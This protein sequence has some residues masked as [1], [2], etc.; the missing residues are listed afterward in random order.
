VCISDEPNVIEKIVEEFIIN[1]MAKRVMYASIQGSSTRGVQASSST[2]HGFGPSR[3][4]TEKRTKNKDDL[5]NAKLILTIFPNYIPPLSN[6]V[7]RDSVPRHF[8]YTMVTVYLPKG[9]C[10]V[11]E[12]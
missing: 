7:S 5:A 1:L 3:V 11:R 6:A 12:Q 2:T 10:T 9:I 8:E 4:I